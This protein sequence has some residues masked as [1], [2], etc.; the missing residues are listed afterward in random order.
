MARS[1]LIRASRM[2]RP[3]APATP[4]GKRALQAFDIAFDGRLTH[5]R[6]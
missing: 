2:A 4:D 3:V 5:N 1:P 6:I